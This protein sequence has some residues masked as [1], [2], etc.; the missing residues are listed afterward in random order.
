MAGKEVEVMISQIHQLK[1]D[2]ARWQYVKKNL[3]TTVTPYSCGNIWWNCNEHWGKG[4]SVDDA[5]DNAIAEKSGRN[6]A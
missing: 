2:A 4:I 6:S 1:K 3:F 5:I